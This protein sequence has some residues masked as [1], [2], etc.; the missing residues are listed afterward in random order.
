MNFVFC[1]SLESFPGL[2]EVPMVDYFNEKGI[3]CHLIDSCA[4][5]Y[6]AYRPFKELL[7]SN[8]LLHYKTNKDPFFMPLSA[9]WLGDYYRRVG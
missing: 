1:L 9:E 2:W 8:F 4:P 6:Q 5:N 7:D 3:S